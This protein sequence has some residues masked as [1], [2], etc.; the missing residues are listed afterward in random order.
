MQI[1][2]VSPT[3]GT[4]QFSIIE[5][6]DPRFRLEPQTASTRCHACGIFFL[7]YRFIVSNNCSFYRRLKNESCSAFTVEEQLP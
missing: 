2:Q 3:Q 1:K 5:T 7:I 6:L 4:A